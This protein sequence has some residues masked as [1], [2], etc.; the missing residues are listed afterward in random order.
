MT[1]LIQTSNK[2]SNCF[3][4]G[5]N[6]QAPPKGEV[7]Y[8]NAF[9]KSTSASAK[10]NKFFHFANFIFSMVGGRGGGGGSKYKRG[11]NVRV[12]FAVGLIFPVMACFFQPSLLLLFMNFLTNQQQ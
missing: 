10:E 8:M 11:L 1:S 7:K 9:T 2:Q 3:Y 5:D 12:F 6:D 4:F